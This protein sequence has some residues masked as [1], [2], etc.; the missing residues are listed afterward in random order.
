MAARSGS[1]AF[2]A[3]AVSGTILMKVRKS[4]CRRRL[5]LPEPLSR[6]TDPPEVRNGVGSK[7]RKTSRA[8]YLTFVSDGGPAVIAIA[9]YRKED[10]DLRIKRC[11]IARQGV[12]PGIERGN[13]ARFPQC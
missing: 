10:V 6:C 7:L 1:A 9:V 4:R 5:K 3:A 2:A 8:G 12:A 11:L 13:T